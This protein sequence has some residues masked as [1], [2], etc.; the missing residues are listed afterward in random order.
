MDPDEIV[1][2]VALREVISP[3]Q[4]GFATKLAA[5]FGFTVIAS[6]N[7]VPSPQAFLANTS[8]LPEVALSR[9]LKVIELKRQGQSLSI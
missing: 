2:P 1:D 3:A 5:G 8:R 7:A 9:N 4:A 6:E